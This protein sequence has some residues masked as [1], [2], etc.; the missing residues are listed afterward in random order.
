MTP[1]IARSLCD[2]WEAQHGK[3][4]DRLIDLAYVRSSENQRSHAAFEC[5]RLVCCGACFHS[6]VRKTTTASTL[7]GPMRRR[8]KTPSSCYSPDSPLP[9][10]VIA[11]PIARCSGDS[12]SF[13]HRR[14]CHGN[15]HFHR[16]MLCSAYYR[17]LS[18]RLSIC[19]MPVFCR[20]G[21]TYPQTFFTIV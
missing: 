8:L 1:S 16:A 14:R 13:S 15:L 2:S 11:C 6:N 20:N 3:W 18:V 5:E 7:L 10:D 4:S 12:S 21:Y 19:H 17:C 9:S